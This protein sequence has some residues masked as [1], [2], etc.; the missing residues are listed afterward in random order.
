MASWAAVSGGQV[1]IR[2][3]IRLR[4]RIPRRGSLRSN[5]SLLILFLFPLP[6]FRNRALKQFDVHFFMFASSIIVHLRNLDRSGRVCQPREFAKSTSQL[7]IRLRRA[8]ARTTSSCRAS[9]TS[10]WSTIDY[11]YFFQTAKQRAKVICKPGI[12]GAKMRSS[13]RTTGCSNSEMNG[14][15]A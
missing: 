4:P 3:C 9:S 5:V 12:I 8:A 14:E 15:T 11:Y 2:V 13:D 6:F 10:A 1:R 7:S